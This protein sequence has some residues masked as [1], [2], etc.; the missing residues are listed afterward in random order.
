ML[1]ISNW[2]MYEAQ[3][4]CYCRD[5]LN[6]WVTLF[7]DEMQYFQGVVNANPNIFQV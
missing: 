1:S 5:L 2:D 6:T 4:N 7:W 3:Y